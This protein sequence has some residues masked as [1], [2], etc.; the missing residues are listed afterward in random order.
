MRSR[1]ANDPESL[2]DQEDN[3][4]SSEDSREEGGREQKEHVTLKDRLAHFTW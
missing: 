2:E 1:Q 4:D 3:G